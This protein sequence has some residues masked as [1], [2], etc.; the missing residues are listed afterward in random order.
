MQ[1]RKRTNDDQMVLEIKKHRMMQEGTKPASLGACDACKIVCNNLNC[2]MGHGAH[3]SLLNVFQERNCR[4]W[5]AMVIDDRL[6][7]ANAVPVLCVAR[8]VACNVK[9][10]ILTPLTYMK[11]DN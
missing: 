7:T 11:L 6:K 2:F 5:M 10:R 4:P 1:K 8:N 3:K 9:I